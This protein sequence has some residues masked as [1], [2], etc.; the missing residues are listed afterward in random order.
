LYLL[1]ERYGK[2]EAAESDLPVL[3]ESVYHAEVLPL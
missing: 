2:L 3:A 1:N